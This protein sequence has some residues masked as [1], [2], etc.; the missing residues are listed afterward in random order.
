MSIYQ[1]ALQPKANIIRSILENVENS[2]ACKSTFRNTASLRQRLTL[3]LIKPKC[4]ATLALGWAS[5]N[6]PENL[7][8]R[9]HSHHFREDR[10]TKRR[11]QFRPG[12]FGSKK[13]GKDRLGERNIMSKTGQG[14]RA[15]GMRGVISWG[16]WKALK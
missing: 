3:T 15:R 9:A 12:W 5:P 7:E 8:E 11:T 1:T 13:M 10:S 14:D 16:G 2:P 4:P 6:S